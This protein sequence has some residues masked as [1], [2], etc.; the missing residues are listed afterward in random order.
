MR[1]AAALTLLVTMA[2][3]QAGQSAPSFLRHHKVLSA[4]SEFAIQIRVP[5][6]LRGRTVTL[7]AWLL[8]PEPLVQ[9]NDYISDWMT[10]QRRERLVLA[11]ESR[12]DV[13]PGR[14]IYRF[15]WRTGLDRGDYEL[16]GV[17]ALAGGR[18][19]RTVPSLIMV[20]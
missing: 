18:M 7:E 14:T 16:V 12:E 10:P 1:A 6:A 9:E 2:L 11:R 5:E 17:V 20:R 3:V 19:V 13:E 8:E 15:V 4:R